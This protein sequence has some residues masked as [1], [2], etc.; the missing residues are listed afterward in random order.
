MPVHWTI[1]VTAVIIISHYHDLQDQPVN[2]NELQDPTVGEAFMD[3]HYK[4]RTQTRPCPISYRQVT[5]FKKEMEKLVDDGVIRGA[6][7]GS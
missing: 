6:Q 1:Q 4:V 3:S 5:A 2:S 7:W